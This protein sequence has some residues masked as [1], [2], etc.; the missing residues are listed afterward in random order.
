MQEQYKEEEQKL[1]KLRFRDPVDFNSKNE[2]I[3]NYR[4]ITYRSNKKSGINDLKYPCN[5]TDIK[6]RSIIPKL[7]AT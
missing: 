5:K 6:A 3:K 7:T 4:K 2:T 1:R